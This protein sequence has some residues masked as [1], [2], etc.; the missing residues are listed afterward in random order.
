MTSYAVQ[1]EPQFGFGYDDVVAIAQT[2]ER[3]GYGALW[4][5][6]HL[7]WDPDATDR[8]CYEVWT[9]LA[10]L[11]PVTSTLRLGTLVS[12]N[13]Y[14]YPTILAKTAAG[15]DAM[16]GGRVNFGIGAGWKEVEYHAYGIPFPSAGTRL[17]QLD[18]AA[19]IVRA[20]FDQD[21]VDFRGEHYRLEGAVCAPKPVQR[22]MPI[23][24]G[25]G[26]ERRTLRIVAERADGWNMVFGLTTAEL[27][28]KLDVL[29]G[30]CDAVG[31]PFAD[32][33]KSIFVHT[34]LY[35]S[36]AERDALT[37]DQVQRLGPV[38]KRFMGGTDKV[39]LAGSPALVAEALRERR[40]LGFEELILLFPYGHERELLE[41]YAAEVLPLVDA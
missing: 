13:S 30:H 16:S 25:G 33:A 17:D 4:A 39:G 12:A 11:V 34:Y 21:K 2:A 22:P 10:G 38:G 14:R 28:H 26:G 15:V 31:R 19:Q 35:T 18:E 23:W 36:D 20:L 27:R 1:I 24:I 41:R 29:R 40:D 9:L 5:S 32:I 6:D 3:Q 7:M 8:N 37:D